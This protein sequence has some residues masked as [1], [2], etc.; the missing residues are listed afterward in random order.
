MFRSCVFA[1]VLAVCSIASAS[2]KVTM[3]LNWIPE[4]EFGG[5][6][7]AK[8]QGA[9]EKHELDVDIKAGGAGAPTWQRVATGQVEFGVS[10]ADEVVIARSTGADVVAIF[11]IYQTCPQGIMVHA[12]RGMKTIDEVFKSGT[13]ALEIG[14][15]YGKFLEKKYGF[16]GVKRVPY[17]GGIANFLA[18]K[19]FAQQCFVFSEPLAAK[20]QGADP[21]TFLIAD[22]GYNPYTGVVVTSGQYA[23]RHP[24]MV[25]AMAAALEEGW[26]TYL[27]DAKPANEVMGKL[28][29]AMDPE[30]FAAAAEAQKT[31]VTGPADE[32]LPLGSMTSERWKTLIDQLVDLK[33]IKS[34]PKAEECFVKP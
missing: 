13:L 10:S 6:Y 19:N 29:K 23:K 33:V 26:K 24:K 30:T 8:E 9:F 3:A 12:S 32:K 14:L 31:L 2:E 7:A 27:A 15:P 16:D 11:T 1:A 25:K 17:T 22:S 5:I 34:A 20:K 4:P 21:Q 28:N 18:D